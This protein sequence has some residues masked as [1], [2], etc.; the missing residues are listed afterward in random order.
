MIVKKEFGTTADGRKV[1]LFTLSNSGGMRVDL[2]TYGAAINSIYVADRNGEFADVLKGFDTI[3]GHEKYSNYQGLTVGRYANRIANGR[4][5]LNGTAY[6]LVKNEKGIT[7]LH[8]GGELSH[9]VWKALITDDNSI[10]MTYSSPDGAEGFPGN[11]DFKVTFILHEDN[12]LEVKYFAVSDKKTVINMTNH[13]YFNL[14]GKGDI[15]SHEL[16][17]NADAFT[18]TD[19]ASIPTG[20]LRPVEGTPFDFRQAKPIGRD[21]NAD[22]GQ[23]KQC[24][25]YDYNFCLNE[26]EGPAAVAYDPES[27]RMMEVFTDLPGVQLYCAN[28]LDGTRPG[29]GGEMLTQYCGFCLET[30]YYPNTPN[31][32]G[33]PQCTFDAGEKFES[34][35]VFRFSVKSN[36]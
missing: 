36:S 7:C 34:T 5:E 1:D 15:L 22:D 20:E 27:G 26:G 21:I 2:I 23:L 11:V 17:I 16:M 19:A 25:G 24:R 18:P 12:S 3:E 29:K 32:P 33:F 10:E 31:M 14:A 35:T 8:G 6:D 13:A 28:F 9:A 4:F 30:Q